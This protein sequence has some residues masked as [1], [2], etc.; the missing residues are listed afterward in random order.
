MSPSSGRKLFG[1][2]G[3]RGV[4]GFEPMTAEVAVRLGRAVAVHFRNG[5][6]HRPRIL[7]GKDTRLSG[8]VL[9]NAL[10]AGI[11]SMGADVLLVGPMPTPGIAFLTHD[12]RADAGVVISASHNPFQDNGIKIFGPDGYK[13]PDAVELELEKHVFEADAFAERHR[14]EPGDLGKAFRIE[15]ARGRYVLSCKRTFPDDLDLDG[16]KI[17]LDCAHGAAYAVSPL[18]FRELGAKVIACGVEPDG[19]NIN[20][21]VGSLHPE[22]VAAKVKETGA[23]IGIALDGDADRAIFVDERGEIV[24]GDKVMAICAKHLL[25]EGRLKDNTL[26]STVMSNVSLEKL[27]ESLGGKLVRTQV[28][29]R[30]VVEQM[31]AGGY[32]L[33]GEQSGHVI[34]LDHATTGDG[35]V[36][37][38]QLLAVMRRTGA[39]LSELAR[40]LELAPQQL[41]NIRVRERVALEENARISDAMKSAEERLS[42]GGRLLVR[43]SGTEPLLRLMAEHPDE[44]L[45]AGVLED[46]AGVVRA[47]LG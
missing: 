1:T 18:V 33:G 12:M 31:R 9:E 19:T 13:L 14:P 43:Y 47:E 36:C 3:I 40:V 22:V 39:S 15:D 34:F 23:A 41:L 20:D 11:C 45:L 38:L 4:A 26:V 7:I 21:G 5:S 28:G 2:D 25:E 27:M 32:T 8:Y 44:G 42:A 6:G 30:Y 37:A 46:L 35:T 29:D 10:V 17:V 16:M 24:D